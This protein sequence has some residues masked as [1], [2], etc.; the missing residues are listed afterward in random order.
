MQIHFGESIV[1]VLRRCQQEYRGVIPIQSMIRHKLEHRSFQD[2]EDPLTKK[3]QNQNA[4]KTY[5][6]GKN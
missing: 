3:N 6:H 1:F 2:D 5:F 4:T